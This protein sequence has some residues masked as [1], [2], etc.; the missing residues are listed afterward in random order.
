M[1]GKRTSRSILPLILISAGV[2][3]VVGAGI[4]VLNP[5]GGAG[6]PATPDQAGSIPYPEVARVNPGDAKAAYDLRQA[7]FLDVRGEPSFSE[8]HIP[9][10]L[11]IT[12]ADLADRLN[13]LDPNAW[14]IPYCT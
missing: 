10:A 2:L 11:S 9:G 5:F 8:G 13:E 7:I 6:V 4:W 14:I 12:E 3:L 1:P